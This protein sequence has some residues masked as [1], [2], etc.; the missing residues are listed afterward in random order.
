MRYKKWEIMFLWDN[1]ALGF[2]LM[3]GWFG[4]QIYRAKIVICHW[5]ESIE[6]VSPPE[7]PSYLKIKK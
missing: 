2:W 1:V 4:L 7:K 6:I 3:Q 5:T